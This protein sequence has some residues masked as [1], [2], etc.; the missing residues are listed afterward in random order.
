MLKAGGGGEK[1]KR[2][3]CIDFSGHLENEL[4]SRRRE[5]NSVHEKQLQKITAI[6][7]SKGITLFEFFVMLDVN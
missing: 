6:L 3:S 1:D 4:V 7:K 2:V 5:A